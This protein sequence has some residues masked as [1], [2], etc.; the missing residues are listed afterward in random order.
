[1]NTPEGQLQ[2]LRGFSHRESQEW[3]AG[4]LTHHSCSP[5]ISC[6][7]TIT[8]DLYHSDLHRNL[9]WGAQLIGGLQGQHLSICHSAPAGV[10]LPLCCSSQWLS[11][12]GYGHEAI[13]VWCR[14]PLTAPFAWGLPISL[15]KTCSESAFPSEAPSALILLPF[16][17]SQVSESIMVGSFSTYSWS[18]PLYPL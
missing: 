2:L 14:T 6:P 15:T 1:M 18:L 10:L 5:S 13:S 8:I 4:I 9:M 7:S 3:V 16:L 17:L 12:M 11:T